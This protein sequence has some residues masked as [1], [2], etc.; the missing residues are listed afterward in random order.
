MFAVLKNVRI[1]TL[2]TVLAIV[3][4]VSG[5]AVVGSSVFTVKQV[6]RLGSIWQSFDDGPATKS[7]YLSQLKGAMGFGGMI[8][9]VKNFVLRRDRPRIPTVHAKLRDVTVALVSYRLIGINEKERLKYYKGEE[10]NVD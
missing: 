8:H 7:L 5:I 10:M 2:G 4:A 1:A 6:N 9:Q 3:L